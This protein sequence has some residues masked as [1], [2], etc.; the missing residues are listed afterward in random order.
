ME[1][2][3]IIA[4]IKRTAA[5]NGG[6]PLGRQRFENETGIK[7]QDWYGKYWARWGDAVTEAG[8]QPNALQTVYDDDWVIEQLISLIRLLGRF[9]TSGEIQIHSRNTPEFPSHDT[10]RR[11]GRKNEILTKV[12]EYC[13][14][15]D[16]HG[17][18]LELCP[19]IDAHVEQQ[20]VDDS[21]DDPSF[22]YV[23]LFKSGK[24][25]KIGHSNSAG[26]RE[27]ELGIQLPERLTTI[28][29]ISTDDPVGI[30]AYWHE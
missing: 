27:Y 15:R 19:P 18:V 24:H 30:E 2:A 28:H 4:E 7:T 26:R 23:Y 6:R 20:I 29:T 13:S 8:Y 14:A 25:Y 16:G 11:L 10:I 21:G 5:A 22:G 1:K 3:H 12:A 9:P 17:D